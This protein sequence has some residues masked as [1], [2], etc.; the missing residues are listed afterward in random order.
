M[1]TDIR[2]TFENEKRWIMWSPLMQTCCLSPNTR[3][4]Y[5]LSLH[6]HHAIQRATVG[7]VLWNKQRQRTY[8]TS[9]AFALAQISAALS[10]SALPSKMP[11]SKPQRS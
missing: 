2:L 10:S 8:I 7:S 5:V 11:A 1:V 4:S 9:Q 3:Y 6:M